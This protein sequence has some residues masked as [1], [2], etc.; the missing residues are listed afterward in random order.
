MATYNKRGYKAPKPTEINEVEPEETFDGKSTTAEVFNTLD[1]GASK[2]EEWVAKN[3]KGIFIIVGIIA[4]AMVSYLVYDKF[5]AS[6]KEDTA[7]DDMFQAQQYFTQAVDAPAANDSLYNLALKGGEGKLGFLGIIENYSGTDA[8]N[9]AH[10]YAG[11][12]YLN[13][14]KYKDAVQHLE[15]FKSKD[16]VLTAMAKGA[17]GDA[18]AQLKQNDEA[19]KYYAAAAKAS[20]ND[21]TAPRFLF[22]AGTIALAQ[23]KKADALKFFKEIQEKYSSSAEGASIDAYVAMAE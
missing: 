23:N 14:G 3:Q 22:K 17:T 21:L 9:L 5:L 15:E 2:T 10:Y 16:D 18:F 20:D 13:T 4:V 19:L 1:Q 12:A 6:P 7:A 11:T 8:A